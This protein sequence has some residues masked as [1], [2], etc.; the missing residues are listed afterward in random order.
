MREQTWWERLKS[1]VWVFNAPWRFKIIRFHDETRL[2][3]G[4]IGVSIPKKERK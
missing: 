1:H 4:R 3:I 2:L